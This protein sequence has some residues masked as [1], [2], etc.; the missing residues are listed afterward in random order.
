MEYIL[1]EDCGNYIEGDLLSH[2]EMIAL[3]AVCKE[4]GCETVNARCFP[5]LQ[6]ALEWNACQVAAR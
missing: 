5:D 6:A 4:A 3:L 2:A 1:L